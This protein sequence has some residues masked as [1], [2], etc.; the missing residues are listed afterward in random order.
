MSS[1]IGIKCRLHQRRVG[2]TAA[3]LPSRPFARPLR[4][5]LSTAKELRVNFAKG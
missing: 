5:V 3:S 1:R 4:T 2:N